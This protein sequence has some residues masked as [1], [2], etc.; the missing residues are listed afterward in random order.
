MKKL[1]LAFSLVLSASFSFSQAFS[2]KGSSYVSAGI[3]FNQFSSSFGGYKGP[4]NINGWSSS[5]YF[6]ISG[7][8][9]YGIH[10]YVGIGG[11]VGASFSGGLNFYKGYVYNP[12]PLYVIAP[13][14]RVYRGFAIPIGVFGNFHFLQL[15]ADKNG[16]SFADKMDV[17]AGVSLGTG[18]SFAMVKRGYK[19]YY[20]PR[21]GVLLYG[22]IHA[23]IRYY[24][25]DN[26]G[27]YGELG[28]GQSVFNTGITFKL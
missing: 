7:Q 5:S 21:A 4:Y 19:D 17:Y 28:Y 10:K 13:Y 24:L 8:Y 22:G 27:V 6:T 14:K 26:I 18:P 20:D 1:I 3:G 16:K 11:F 12:D 23:G 2:G 15:I 25:K 9:E